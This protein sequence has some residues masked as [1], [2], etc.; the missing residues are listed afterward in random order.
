MSGSFN[1]QSPVYAS[2]WENAFARV[3]RECADIR[4]EAQRRLENVASVQEVVLGAFRHD[5]DATLKLYQRFDTGDFNDIQFD[6]GSL[7]GE[8]VTVDDLRNYLHPFRMPDISYSGDFFSTQT[9]ASYSF[10]VPR[11]AV[12][13][14]VLGKNLFF[15]RYSGLQQAEVSL[16]GFSP[17]GWLPVLV[18]MEGIQLHFARDDAMT[19]IDI[20][21]IYRFDP[22]SRNKLLQTEKVAAEAALDIYRHIARGYKRAGVH[23]QS[24]KIGRF[25]FILPVRDG[26]YVTEFLPEISLT[27]ADKLEGRVYAPFA[28]VG[29]VRNDCGDFVSNEYRSSGRIVLRGDDGSEQLWRVLPVSTASARY[30]QQ[31]VEGTI[32]PPN[33][34]MDLMNHI[35][36]FLFPHRRIRKKDAPSSQN[37]DFLPD[38]RSSAT[39]AVRS[40]SSGPVYLSKEGGEP[41]IHEA[42]VI[43]G[44]AGWI[45]ARRRT[46]HILYQIVPEYHGQPFILLGRVLTVRFHV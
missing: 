7:F 6:L 10:P 3:E 28:M 26:K 12:T 39:Q 32:L 35:A 43:P 17:F 22:A 33:R 45:S 15:N 37:R 44:S 5:I 18:D 31:E 20:P 46:D 11:I 30:V 14:N 19:L 9:Q 23:F 2:Q 24:P 27:E 1:E 16:V 40:S 8:D 41:A 34:S 21:M 38:D 13:C 25:L 36:L 42:A 29:G 4:A